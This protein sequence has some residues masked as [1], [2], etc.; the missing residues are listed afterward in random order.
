MSKSLER[1]F[2]REKPVSAILAVSDTQ[3]TY[4]ALVAKKID[5]TFPHTCGILNEL[6]A[7]GLLT[8]RPV[9][10]INYLELTDRG[11]SVAYALHRLIDELH[12]SDGYRLRLMRL[13]KTFHAVQDQ[14]DDRTGLE[15]DAATERIVLRIGPLRRDLARLISQ[16]DESLRRDA[17]EMDAAIAAIVA[18]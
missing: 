4:A 9:G 11:K 2:L 3:P 1:L 12:G 7:Q 10:R 16:G 18:K 17:E 8:S 6:E 14:I 15:K 5:S 13:E